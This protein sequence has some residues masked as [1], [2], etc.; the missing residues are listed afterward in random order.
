[1]K[2]IYR[3]SKS[4][5][6]LNKD[7][8]SDAL[9]HTDFVPNTGSIFWNSDDEKTYVC[10]GYYVRVVPKEHWFVTAEPQESRIK[11]ES[12]KALIKNAD[13]TVTAK[14]TGNKRDIE[15]QTVVELQNE[16]GLYSY[17]NEKYLKY[18]EDEGELIFR[19]SKSTSPV[20]IE[21]YDEI[22]GIILP[23]RV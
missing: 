8:L 16:N 9:K 6:K 19:F 13:N 1:M 22:I 3:L 17:V 10:N 18:F 23:V 14:L 11:T 2:T 5:K 15:K 21:A 12:L 7:A 20:V 4:V